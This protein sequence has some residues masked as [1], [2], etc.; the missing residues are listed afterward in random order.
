MTRASI[1]VT[2]SFVDL[3]NMVIRATASRSGMLYAISIDFSCVNQ[4]VFLG[5][6][7]ERGKKSS[8]GMSEIVLFERERVA[9][10]TVMFSGTS[11]QNPDKVL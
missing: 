9:D 10:G 5:G 4:S 11:G 3:D 2:L 6:N 8:L 7:Q 1:H